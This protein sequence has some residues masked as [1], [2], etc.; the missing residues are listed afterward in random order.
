MDQ[1][2]VLR[3][4]SLARALFDDT[5]FGD[6]AHR[7]LMYPAFSLKALVIDLLQAIRLP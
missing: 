4:A 6:R 3:V 7:L 1:K 2:V 5:L